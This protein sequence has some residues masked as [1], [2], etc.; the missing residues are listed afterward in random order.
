MHEMSLA[1]GIREIVETNAAAH[2]VTRIKA[3]R[4]EIGRFA[5]V[6]KEAL[7]FC[8]DVVMKGSVAEDAELV[9]IDLPASAMCFGCGATVEIENRLDPCPNC[10]GHRLSPVS[11][12]EMRV[13]DLEAA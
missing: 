13:K 11:G 2:N 8:F 1:E 3:V 9:M 10:G 6:E 12:D 4:V 7:A 5:G